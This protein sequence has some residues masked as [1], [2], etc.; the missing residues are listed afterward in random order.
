MI[1]FFAIFMPL[2][3]VGYFVDIKGAILGGVNFLLARLSKRNF[4]AFF[5]S[6][7]H[8]YHLSYGS[9]NSWS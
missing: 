7:F 1:Q 3:G 8:K 4:I 6:R 5:G 2:P 9:A